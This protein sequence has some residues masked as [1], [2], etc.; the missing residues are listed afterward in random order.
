MRGGAGRGGEATGAPEV[1]EVDTVRQLP[2]V[3]WHSTAALMSWR[4]PVLKRELE[5]CGVR[6]KEMARLEKAELAAMVLEKGGGGTSAAQCAVCLNDYTD[7][8]TL[9]VLPCKHR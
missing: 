6:L 9:R 3:I 5:K 8:E 2:L 7:G 1:A 4:V